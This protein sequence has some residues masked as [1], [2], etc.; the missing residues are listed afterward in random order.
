MCI[1]TAVKVMNL[2]ISFLS[3]FVPF[4]S[5]SIS[6]HRHINTDLSSVSTQYLFP[7]CYVNG[8]IRYVLFGLT[9]PILQSYFQ[10]HPCWWLCHLYAVVY[11]DFSYPNPVLFL[12]CSLLLHMLK[13]PLQYCYF[14]LNNC[15][16]QRFK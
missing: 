4:C 16:L 9:S 6:V 14:P 10:I 13:D 12:S 7:K 3:F 15:L 2:P 11:L 8:V 1:T 5:L